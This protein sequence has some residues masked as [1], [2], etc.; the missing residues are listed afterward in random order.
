VIA[1]DLEAIVSVAG[2]VAA[3]APVPDVGLGLGLPAVGLGVGVG[4][5]AAHAELSMVSLIIVTAPLR[6]SAR[7]W[8]V[9]PLFSA[10]EVRPRSCP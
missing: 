8:S 3:A 7:P 2:A 10:M 5:G 9:T 1:S 4:L 6:A